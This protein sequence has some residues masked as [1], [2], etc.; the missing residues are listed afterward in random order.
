M[1]TTRTGSG[2]ISGGGGGAIAG[3]DLAPINARLLLMVAL[4]KTSD[5]NELRRIFAEY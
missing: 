1:I 2:R 4:T 5:T 3:Q